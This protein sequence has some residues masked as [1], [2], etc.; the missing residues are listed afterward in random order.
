MAKDQIRRLVTAIG[1]TS[2]GLGLFDAV[3]AKR[4][5]RGVGITSPTAFRLA[6]AREIATGA[7]A[8]AAP[9]LAWPIAARLAGDVVDLAT[10]GATAGTKDGSKRRNAAIGVGIVAL[11]TIVDAFALGK[12]RGWDAA[13]SR[14]SSGAAA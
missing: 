13:T 5:A 6:A 10:L 1:W 14:K 4:L 8:V 11:V 12:L 9:T 7:G 2:I 3:M